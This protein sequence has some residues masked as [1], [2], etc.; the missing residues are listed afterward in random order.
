LKTAAVTQHHNRVVVTATI[1]PAQLA[2][3]AQDSQKDTAQ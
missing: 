1:T 3:M 2:G